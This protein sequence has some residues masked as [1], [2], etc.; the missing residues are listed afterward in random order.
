LIVGANSKNQDLLGAFVE[1]LG[2]STFRADT[3]EVLDKM[4]D[5]QHPLRFALIDITGFDAAIWERCSRLH[6]LD[7]PLLVI[8]PKQS[9]AVR[10]LSFAHGAQ[11]VLE[12]PLAMRELADAIHS[13]MQDKP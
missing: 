3:L 5:E 1:R 11:T 7:I 13:L 12:K 4:L 10:K 9:A 2:Y 8:S 6:Q